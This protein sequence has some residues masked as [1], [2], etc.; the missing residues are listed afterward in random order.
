[1]NAALG[2]K[3]AMAGSSRVLTKD[4]ASR[5]KAV[6][7]RLGELVA[8]LSRLEDQTRQAQVEAQGAA[9]RSAEAE[10]AARRIAEAQAGPYHTTSNG[11]GSG[12]DAEDK[13]LRL[14]AVVGRLDERVEKITQT[15]I[16]Q[17]HRFS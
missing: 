2:R 6:E 17:A 12:G 1:M 15:L 3:M 8:M 9:N 16:Q 14:Q 13:F 4:L 7:D 11:N 10:A 5:L